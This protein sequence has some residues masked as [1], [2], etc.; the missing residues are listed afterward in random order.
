MKV[1]KKVDLEL[2]K[3]ISFIEGDL[4]AGFYS[5][6]ENKIASLIDTYGKTQELSSIQ[7]KCLINK[8]LNKINKTE[9]EHQVF[10]CGE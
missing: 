10:Y 6:A 8:R 1:K 3:E 2:K 4:E 9:A 5:K 7:E